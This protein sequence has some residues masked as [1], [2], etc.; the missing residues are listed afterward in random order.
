MKLVIGT[1]IWY[2]YMYGSEAAQLSRPAGIEREPDDLLA[3]PRAI[4]GQRRLPRIPQGQVL[5]GRG[6]VPVLRQADQVP[7]DQ[8]PRRLLLPVLSP[9]GV[10]HGRDDLPQE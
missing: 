3:V 10:P 4:P 9:P 7:P 1:C 2:I 5:P 6:R 8:E